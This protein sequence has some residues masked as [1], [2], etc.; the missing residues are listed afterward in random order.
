MTDVDLTAQ[1]DEDVPGEDSLRRYLNEIGR[2]P[3]LTRADEVQLAKRVEAG[4]PVAKQRLVE[5]NLRLVVTI[6][7]TFRTGA[8]DLLD[9]VQEGTLGLMKAAERYDWRRGTKFSTYA[10]WWIRAGIME[11]LS[12]TSHPIRLPDS[13]R[14]RIGDVNRAEQELTNRL[15]RRPTVAEIADELALTPTQVTEA[16]AAGQA[17]GSLDEPL[18]SEGAL[19]HADLIADPNLPDPL[20]GLVEEANESELER[21]LSTLPERSRRVIE[22]RFGVGGGVARTADAVAAELGV[23]R[24]RVRQIELNALRRLGATEAASLPRAA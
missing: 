3:L 17:V 21:R 12:A 16:R 11:A 18:G 23:A 10:S 19:R 7:K 8:L 14:E 9:L 22:L 20:Q 5:S 1:T 15:C 2:Y 24:E 4:D 13:I 6:A